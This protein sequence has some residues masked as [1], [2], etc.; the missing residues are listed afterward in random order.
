MSIPQTN[1]LVTFEKDPTH[2]QRDHNKALRAAL[3]AAAVYHHRQHIPLH[4]KAGNS[5]RY[6]YAPR[7]ADYKKYKRKTYG[8]STDFVKTGASKQLATSQRQIA[9][10][11]KTVKLKLQLPFKGGATGR[12][13]DEAARARMGKAPPSKK[14]ISAQIQLLRRMAEIQT[15][16][17]SEVTALAKEVEFQ[18]VNVINQPSTPRRKRF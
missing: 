15:F 10:T 8:S 4:F 9:A 14:Q 13:L 18:Y 12:V 3:T 6:H 5:S 17:E 11:P 16:T 7:N 2:F 1:F